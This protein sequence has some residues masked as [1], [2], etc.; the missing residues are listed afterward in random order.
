MGR[1]VPLILGRDLFD[2]V[3]VDLDFELVQ[4]AFHDARRTT[5]AS[6]MR[7]LRIGRADGLSN[8]PLNVEGGRSILARFDLG[9]SDALTLS[10]DY[11]S[12]HRTL[13]LRE[14]APTRFLGVAGFVNA[15]LLTVGEVTIAGTSLNAV[16]TRVPEVYSGSR[17][18]PGPGRGASG[19][20]DYCLG[21]GLAP[22]R[23]GHPVRHLVNG[24]IPA[25]GSGHLR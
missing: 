19:G 23:C 24:E 11:V 21:S 1:P 8:I 22:D 2:Q 13:R 6:G 3:M 20:R 18:S 25:D 9:D 14:G 12:G 17:P 4:V 7:S 16:P 10:P 5:A 15:R